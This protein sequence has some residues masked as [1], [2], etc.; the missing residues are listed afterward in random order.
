M[1]TLQDELGKQFSINRLAV[2]AIYNVT[3]ADTE[4][5]TRACC[6]THIA[7]VTDQ[8]ILPLANLYTPPHTHLHTPTHT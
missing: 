8:L 7:P 1:G 5:M 3:Q 4:V 2:F 6:I